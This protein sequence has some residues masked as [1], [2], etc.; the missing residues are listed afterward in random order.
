MR[1]ISDFVEGVS[2]QWLARTSRIGPSLF[3][4][5]GMSRRDGFRTLCILGSHPQAAFKITN[6]SFSAF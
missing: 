6:H 2:K 3:I 4:V 5:L 1:F